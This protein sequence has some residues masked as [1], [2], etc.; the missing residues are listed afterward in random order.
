[1]EHLIQQPSVFT[2]WD[3]T[4]WTE[5][6]DLNT[7]R[8]GPGGQE[9]NTASLAFGGGYPSNTVNA[10]LWDGSSWTEVNNLNT[11]RRNLGGTGT[12]TSALAYGV[13]PPQSITNTESWNGTSWTEVADLAH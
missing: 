13:I 8:Q 3:G 11:A 7:A 12:T 10:E 9:L 6:N 2:E 1:M 4:S 5:V